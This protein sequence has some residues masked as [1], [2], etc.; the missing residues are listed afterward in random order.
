MK[1]FFCI[2][3]AVTGLVATAAAAP[4]LI[5]DTV[6]TDTDAHGKDRVLARFHLL[7]LNKKQIVMPT[8]S[9][10]YAVTP[11][12]RPDGTVDLSHT[13]THPNYK[14]ESVTIGPYHQNEPLGETSEVS[15]GSITYATK[16]AKAK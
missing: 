10:R 14:G 3:L 6:V 15:F 16:V 11:T 12:L 1:I 8:G 7:T 2:L 4:R 5:V 9:R 13:M